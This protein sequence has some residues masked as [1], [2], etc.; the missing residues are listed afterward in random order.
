VV[1][2]EPLYDCYLPMV[3][4]A[5]AV[6]KLVRLEPPDWALPREALAAAFSPRTKLILFNSPMNPTGKVFDRS[7]LEFIAGLMAEHDSYAICDEV[8]EHL[9]FDGLAHVPLMTL[10]GMRERAVRIASAGKTFSLTGWKVGY[11]TC[12]PDLLQ[13]IAKAH[14]FLVFT[15]PPNLQRAVAQGLGKDD[16]FFRALAD[17][18]QSKRDRLATP[19]VVYL[20]VGGVVKLWNGGGDGK[21]H[22][23]PG[24]P[25]LPPSQGSSGAFS[26]PLT[27]LMMMYRN[28]RCDRP[29]NMPPTD[30]KKFRSAN[31]G[32]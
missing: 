23:R 29:N 16:S 19:R 30:D 18:L 25:I 5:G 27:V 17:S 26:P 13:P 11:I 8:Y 24:L 20:T 9:V 2:L 31:C 22:S 4:R 6:P 28:S 21:V 32:L 1:L 3:Q 14:Q 15:T 7:E 12:A 10:P